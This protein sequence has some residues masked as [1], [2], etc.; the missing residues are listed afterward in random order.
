MPPVVLF[1]LVC[2]CACCARGHHC[3]TGAGSFLGAGLP[4]SIVSVMV[5]GPGSGA[6][7]GIVVHVHPVVHVVVHCARGSCADGVGPWAWQRTQNIVFSGVGCAV[8]T[9]AVSHFVPPLE[10][11]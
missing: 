5:P 7:V 2:D 1:A 11:W 8:G 10:V 6:P 3:H 4:L 9:V